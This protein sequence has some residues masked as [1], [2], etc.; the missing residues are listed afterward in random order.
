MQNP[1]FGAPLKAIEARVPNMVTVGVV[2][3]LQFGDK[4]GPTAAYG[5]TEIGNGGL[6]ENIR[7]Y[8]TNTLKNSTKCKTQSSVHP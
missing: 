2:R 1:S 3:R 5:M 7:N 4:V 8:G 6:E